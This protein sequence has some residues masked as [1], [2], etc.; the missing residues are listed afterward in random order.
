M[1]R[2]KRILKEIKNIEEFDKKRKNRI[3]R[4]AILTEIFGL[5]REILKIPF[6]LMYG[7]INTIEFGFRIVADILEIISAILKEVTNLF[8]R[9]PIIQFVNKKDYIE[10]L[11]II[12]KKN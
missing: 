9:L 5:Y 8:D 7:V 11:E 3:I 2:Y 6:F 10:T 4:G 1:I 12:R